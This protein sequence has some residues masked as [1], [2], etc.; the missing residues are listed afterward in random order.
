MCAR[1]TL[2]T[3]AALLR[4]IFGL[5]EL[6]P[7]PR[8]GGVFVPS[9]E[10]LAALAGRPRRA[11]MLRWGWQPVA[12]G[13]GLLI[14]ARSETLARSPLFGHALR[15]ARCAI[16]AD[17]FIEWKDER[18]RKQP[19]L[20]Q[21]ADRSPFAIAG[22]WREDA[23]GGAARCTLVTTAANA[24]VLP[25]HGRMPAVLEPQ[26]L[27]PWLD[28]ELRDLSRLSPLLGPSPTEGWVA[29]PVVPAPPQSSAEPPLL[30]WMSRS[31]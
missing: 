23:S 4:V 8:P 15:S 31:T 24:C 11:Q 25:V 30:A 12:A 19:L 22:L 27:E 1:F 28:S 7:E 20:F 17:G 2:T 13:A 10:V 18:G 6:P 3:A 5:D 21:R 29:S 26:D 9:Q 16:L 14:N